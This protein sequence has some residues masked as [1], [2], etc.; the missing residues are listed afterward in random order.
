MLGWCLNG[1]GGCLNGVGVVSERCW[2]T[3][4]GNYQCFARCLNSVG[5]VSGR[6]WEVSERCWGGVRTVL[7]G[8]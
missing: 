8:V 6:C 1:V 3:W 4:H 7:G 5:V 2:A